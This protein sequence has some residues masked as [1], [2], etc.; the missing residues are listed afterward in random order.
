VPVG[1]A[2]LRVC[3]GDGRAP[4]FALEP[5]I[6]PFLL[7]PHSGTINCWQNTRIRIVSKRARRTAAEAASIHPPISWRPPPPLDPP[8]AVGRPA[9]PESSQQQAAHAGRLVRTDSAEC[10]PAAGSSRPAALQD[11]V[12][13]GATFEKRIPLSHTA[14]PCCVTPSVSR[15]FSVEWIRSA[16]SGALSEKKTRPHAPD[17]QPASIRPMA[18]VL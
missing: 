16:R 8:L 17:T 14:Y 5:Q 1:G 7:T 4:P 13:W 6:N 2:S 15:R 10:E 9:T 11:I 12:R 18:P 3:C